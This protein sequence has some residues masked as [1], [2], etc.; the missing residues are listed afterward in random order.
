MKLFAVGVGS[1]TKRQQFG[2]VD[3]GSSHRHAQ[4]PFVPVN[5][6]A[7]LAACLAPVRGIAAD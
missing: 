6:Y 1:P 2:V 3:V 7:S 5:H 4:R